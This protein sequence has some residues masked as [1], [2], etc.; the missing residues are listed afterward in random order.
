MNSAI[1]GDIVE[2]LARLGNRSGAEGLIQVDAS[3]AA[4]ATLLG[5]LGGGLALAGETAEARKQA[6]AIALLSDPDNR[7]PF[8]TTAKVAA[9]AHI[10]VELA[11]A[12]FTEDA[13][14]IAKDLPDSLPSD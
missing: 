5:R 9:Q 14:A 1:R 10:A 8:L 6:T 13:M 7:Y 11:T 12:G 2:K 3:P 4:H